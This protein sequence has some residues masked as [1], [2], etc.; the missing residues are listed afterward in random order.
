ME[1]YSFRVPPAAVRNSRISDAQRWREL[2]EFG[3]CSEKLG[4]FRVALVQL[5]V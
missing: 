1:L 3:T 2:S 5:L 4:K